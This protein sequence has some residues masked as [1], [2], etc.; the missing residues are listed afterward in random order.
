MAA[1]FADTMKALEA[2]MAKMTPQ[3]A[4]KNIE[5]WEAHIEGL[6]VSGA[7]TLLADLGALK[8]AL[9]KDP[10]DGAAVARLMVKLAAG[11]AR[12]AGRI[13]G[14]RTGQV[15]ALAQALE[16]AAQTSEAA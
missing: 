11:T 3:Q 8:R 12:I 16:G 15:E 10:I 1:R 9:Q 2:G 14:R 13:E 5:T 6:D 7:K 4:I